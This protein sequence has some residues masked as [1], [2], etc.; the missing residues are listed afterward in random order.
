MRICGAAIDS[1][2]IRLGPFRL[3]KFGY[4]GASTRCSSC[5]HETDHQ[6]Y[7]QDELGGLGPGHYE[8]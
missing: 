5:R 8:S 7:A 4:R 3:P 6:Y 2:L 1:Y